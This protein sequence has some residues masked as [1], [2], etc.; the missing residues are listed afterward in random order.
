MRIEV[1]HLR[2]FRGI[3]DCVVTLRPRLT[4]LVGRNNSGKSRILRAIA[5][6]CGGV[7]AE[8]D[9]FTLGSEEEPTVD[10]ILAPA[11]SADSFDDRVREIFGTHLQLVSASGDER[12][13][14]RTSITRSAEGWGARATSRF[15]MYDAGVD[16]W[17]PATG[18]S[19]VSRRQRGVLA[20][21]IAGTGRDLA[22][23]LS[24]PGTSIRRVLDDLE[25]PEAARGTLEAD[26]QAL[27]G[28]IV[29]ESS[30][31]VVRVGNSHRV[32]EV[33]SW[34]HGESTCSGP[35]AA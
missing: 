33:K 20:A 10:L 27:G 11:D 15:L 23:E 14:W 18:A 24:R 32:D 8:R 29:D 22:G 3:D 4:L 25:V 35:G 17:K 21:D 1:V 34:A 16:E 5:L 30:A 2:S 7:S 28:R 6:A 19:E 31:L 13:A 26:L 9:D 12:V